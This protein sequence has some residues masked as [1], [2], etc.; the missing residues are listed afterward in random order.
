M[1]QTNQ[2]FYNIVRYC[3]KKKKELANS[4]IRSITLTLGSS[5]SSLLILEMKNLK[6]GS[7]GMCPE[8]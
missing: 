6:S 2:I 8:S 1:F 3:I 7:D 5:Q 4:V